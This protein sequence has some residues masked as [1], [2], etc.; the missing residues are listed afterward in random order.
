[1]RLIVLF[2]LCLSWH[3]Y[4]V[5]ID[6][7]LIHRYKSELYDY[8]RVLYFYD[9][10]NNKPVWLDNTEKVKKFEELIEASKFYG[11]NPYSYKVKER[12]NDIKSEILLTDRVIKLVYDNYFGVINPKDVYPTWN[13]ER[14]ED[15]LLEKLLIW[16]NNNKLPDVLELSSP[17]YQQYKHLSIALQK[18]YSLIENGFNL[19]KIKLKETLK[20]GDKNPQIEYIKKYLTILGDYKGNNF[21]ENF[22]EELLEAIKKFQERHGLKVDGIIGKETL[23]ELNTPI[24]DRIKAIKVNMEKIRWLPERLYPNRIEINIPSFDLKFY[25]EDKP[26]IKMKIIVGKNYIEDFRPTPIYQGLLRELVIN[27]YWYTPDKIAAKD[28]LPK[29]KKNPNFL[30]ENNFKVFYKGKEINPSTVNWKL[31]TEN[32]FPFKLVQLPGS[33]N[34]L[35]KIKFSFDNPFGVYLHDTPH[36]ELFGEHIRAFSSGCIR[37]ED[38]KNLAE[39]ILLIENYDLNLFESLLQGSETKK[40]SIKSKIMVNILYFTVNYENENI[41]FFKDIYRYDKIISDKLSLR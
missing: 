29:I 38:A 28:I 4:A 7:S 33:K 1:M 19:K 10:N 23:R 2:I 17:K 40:I 39:R 22:E 6:R 34:A 3:S 9:K 13:Y 31:F 41:Y 11:L 21:D 26:E 35:G 36:K 37:V 8:K 32:Y 12:N 25:I 20:Y 27:P 14:K 5:K 24:E 15:N 16:L 18:Y 30:K